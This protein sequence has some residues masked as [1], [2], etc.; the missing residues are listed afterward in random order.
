MEQYFCKTPCTRDIVI[1]WMLGMEVDFTRTVKNGEEGAEY[2][3]YLRSLTAGDVFY[4]H[5][6]GRQHTVLRVEIDNHGDR[7]IYL[8]ESR[9][10]TLCL[11][12]RSTIPAG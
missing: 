4:D 7:V 12:P 8:D 2:M 6:S 9:Y 5:G 10:T 3:N 1:K 11:V